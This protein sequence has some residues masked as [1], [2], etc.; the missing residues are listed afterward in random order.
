VKLLLLAFLVILA[1]NAL[2]IVA[3]AGILIIDHF[4][5]RRRAAGANAADE[6]AHANAS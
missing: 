4:R 1:L 2:V 5:A 3:V 6:D